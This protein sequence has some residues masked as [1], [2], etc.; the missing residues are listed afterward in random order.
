L[1]RKNKSLKTKMRRF[2]TKNSSKKVVCTA[3]LS[4]EGQI[5]SLVCQ[6]PQDGG[7]PNDKSEFIR[8]KFEELKAANPS[9]IRSAA[10]QLVN[11]FQQQNSTPANNH[12]KASTER[13]EVQ[14]HPRI[15]KEYDFIVVGSG[16]GGGACA[17]ALLR[18]G[19][20]VLVLE[21]GIDM[22]KS[23]AISE[24]LCPG[25]ENTPSYCTVPIQQTFNVTTESQPDINGRTINTTWARVAGGCSAHNGTVYVLPDEH[26]FDTWQSYTGGAWSTHHIRKQLNDYRTVKDPVANVI[27]GHGKLQVLQPTRDNAIADIFGQ[28]IYNLYGIPPTEANNFDLF[29]NWPQP[30]FTQDSSKQFTVPFLPPPANV[31]SE[32]SWSSKAFLKSQKNLT[33][34]TN[35]PC[36]RV[37]FDDKVAVGVEYFY[38]GKTFFSHAKKGVVLA[39]GFQ[40]TAKLLNISGIGSK[41]TLK[42]LGITHQVSTAPAGDNLKLQPG[43]AMFMLL[44]AQTVINSCNNNINSFGISGLQAVAHLPDQTRPQDA[45]KRGWQLQFNPF[46]FDAYNAGALLDIY[47]FLP[48][49]TGTSGA[50]N[51]DPTFNP[52]FQPNMLQDPADLT[53]LAQIALEI[54]Q[55]T[56]YIQANYPGFIVAIFDGTFTSDEFLTDV[57]VRENWIKNNIGNAIHEG[58]TCRMGPNNG[59]NVVDHHGAVY[60]TKNLYVADDSVIPNND[61]ESL[62]PVYP[63]N[64]Q[65]CAYIIGNNIGEQLAHKNKHSHSSSSH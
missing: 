11:F 20:K 57:S 21:A 64:T 52:A 62:P 37:V 61:E 63:G 43:L 17:G 18:H 59:Q 12:C 47:F 7:Q 28:T 48:L 38:N 4:P 49:S 10:K 53:S 16:P 55:F 14:N 3:K 23:I 6:A 8:Q 2:Q 46:P 5:S 27:E 13:Q 41:E 50:L 25:Q 39:A 54:R 24:G 65:A 36:L 30:Q 1:T 15:E 56:D 26:Y 19:Y 35:S 42:S 33:F 44:D 51:N 60:G 9:D 45:N 34:L 29:T 32:R 40:N 58:G 31:Q 22:D